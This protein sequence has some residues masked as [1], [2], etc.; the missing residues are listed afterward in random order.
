MPAEACPAWRADL[1]GAAI[2]RLEPAEHTRLLAHLD[3]C[4][5]CRAALAELQQTARLVQL[6]DVEHVMGD[7]EPALPPP[8]GDAIVARL[9]AEQARERRRRA[10]RTRAWLAAA[11]AVIVLVIVVSVA[12]LARDGPRAPSQRVT[13]GG[14][15]V[16]ATAQIV[17][18]ESGTEVHLRG[19]GVDPADVYWLWLTG[20]DGKRVGAGTFNGGSK[21]TFDVS[22]YSALPYSQVRRV[23]VTDAQDRVVLDGFVTPA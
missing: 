3:G 10:H 1:A 18:D 17:A 12:A 14:N 6:A 9:R 19:A 5:A 21:G 22:T 23:W 11:A 7:D 15:H 16:Q 8:L 13:L 4:P 2:G 20:P